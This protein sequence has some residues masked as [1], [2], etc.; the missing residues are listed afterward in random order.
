[1]ALLNNAISRTNLLSSKDTYTESSY[2]AYLTAYNAAVLVKNNAAN[3]TATEIKTAAQNLNNA[4]EKLELALQS[5]KEELSSLIVECLDIEEDD[6]TPTSYSA[7]EKAFDNARNAVKGTDVNTMKQAMTNLSKA[8]NALELIDDELEDVI[9]AV[10]KMKNAENVSNA[11]NMNTKTR[12]DKLNKIDNI[13]KAVKEDLKAIIVKANAKADEQGTEGDGSLD[14][15]IGK[16]KSVLN[17]SS[18]SLSDMVNA[19]D[20]LNTLIK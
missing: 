18:S 11:L 10:D 8:K 6:Y 9:N 1:M 13:K 2:N 14:T 3:K 17:S 5:I 7:F 12:D 15:A 16:A 4:I 20:M 19:Y